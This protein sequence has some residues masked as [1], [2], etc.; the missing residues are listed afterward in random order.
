MDNLGASVRVGVHAHAHAHTAPPAG[1]DGQQLSSISD[2][3]HKFLRYITS[4]YAVSVDTNIRIRC[5]QWLL[6]EQM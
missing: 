6:S 3:F 4:D 2:V 5:V 1:Q